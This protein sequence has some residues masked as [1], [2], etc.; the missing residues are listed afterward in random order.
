MSSTLSRSN[1]TLE[2]AHPAEVLQAPRCDRNADYYEADGGHLVTETIAVRTGT[3]RENGS[4][5]DEEASA[6]R[7]CWAQAYKKMKEKDPQLSTKIQLPGEDDKNDPEKIL[8]SLRK[9][10]KSAEPHPRWLEQSIRSVLQ[11]K[12][13][14]SAAAS[15][16]PFKCAPIVVKGIVLILEVVSPP[17]MRQMV[18]NL[19]K[20]INLGFGE[21][22]TPTTDR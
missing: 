22:A 9:P 3:F 10:K 12:E 13:L 21:S 6:T 17:L 4:L 2:A 18:R 1:A 5:S 16:D 20:K 7:S 19:Q 8:A 15:L 14:F 11:F